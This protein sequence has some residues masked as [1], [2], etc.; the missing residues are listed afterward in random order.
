MRQAVYT[1]ARFG[2]FLSLSD[3]LREKNGGKNLSFGQK[4]AASLTAGCLASIVGTPADV[5]L[6]RF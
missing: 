5:I 2:I 6:I 3:Y 4:G 1:T